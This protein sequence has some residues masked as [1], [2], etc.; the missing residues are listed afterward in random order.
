MPTF[1]G[2]VP[3]EITVGYVW[4][5]SV[6]VSVF[7]CDFSP[8]QVANP[9]AAQAGGGRSFTLPAGLPAAMV[10]LKGNGGTPD[11]TLSGPNGQTIDTASPPH[12]P[13]VIVMSLGGSTTLVALKTPAGGTWTVTPDAGTVL[14]T[15]GPAR[16]PAPLPRA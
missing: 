8:Y 6:H 9:R 2:T 1:F 12:D 13:K 3:V 5:G 16:V 7:D 14:R 11:V 10:E 15:P 4:G